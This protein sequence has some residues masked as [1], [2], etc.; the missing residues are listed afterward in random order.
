MVKHSY[1]LQNIHLNNSWLTIGTFD[2]VHLGHQ[3]ILSSLRAGAQATNA[4]AVVLTFHP[5]PAVFLGK[6]QNPSSLT[7]PEE[8]AVLMGD[9]G[10]DLMITYPFDQQTATTP[11]QSFIELLKEHLGF[12]WLGM[13]E[14]FAL[15]QGRQGDVNF[16]R[17]IS[18]QYAYQLQVFPPVELDGK[19]IS[20]S[21]IRAYLAEGDVQSAA[22]ML[23]RPYRVSGEVVEGDKRGRTI[24]IP[25][26]NLLLNK[27]KVA[28]ASGVY[29]CRA[30][31]GD[32]FFVAAVNIG[33]RPT[34]DGEHAKNWVEA[35]LLD[36]SGDLYGQH[37]S[38]DFYERLRGEQRFAGVEELLQQIRRDIQKTREVVSV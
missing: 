22:S 16:L 15:G 18:E 35:H 25:T 17:S 13:G 23:G 11:A 31:V 28:P 12:C 32:D 8:R 29:A 26:A 10:I 34:F 21:R 3:A 5:Q 27:E 33:S 38:L 2:G 14:D 20:S 4:P 19:V 6:R 7:T 37:I 1:S 24:G 30:K 9:L 36:F